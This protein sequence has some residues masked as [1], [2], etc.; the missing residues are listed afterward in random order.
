MD[1]ART[2]FSARADGRKSSTELPSSACDVAIVG[3]GPYGLAAAARLHELAG[4]DTRV[5]G[6]PM[7]FWEGM[8][9]GMLLRSA[10]EACSIGFPSGELS[11]DHYQTVSGAQFGK[12]VPLEAFVGYGCWFQRTAVPTVDQR[13]VASITHDQRGYH[14]VLDDRETI[15][16][17]RVIVAAGIGYFPWRPREFEQ[18]PPKLASH[19]SEHRDLSCFAGRNV[20]VV[21]GGQSALES[22]ALLHESGAA[23]EVVARAPHITWLHGGVVQRKLGAAKPLLYAKTDVGPAGISRLVA[24][25]GLFCSLPRSAQSVLAHRAIRPAGAK[26]L[27]SRLADVSIS[28]GRRVVAAVPSGDF[29]DLLLDDGSSR[30]AD[31]VILG[32]G[33]R[34]DI[35]DY[36]FLSPELLREVRCVGGYPVLRGGLESS[37]PGLHFAGAPAAWSFGPIMRFVSG[38]WFAAQA[39]AEAIG[40]SPVALQT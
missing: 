2:M 15:R 8:P 5:F 38:S 6:K 3:A 22:A 27:V 40:K 16:A 30:R 36:G 34:V 10:W 17:A 35:A 13:A 26:W 21:G 31:H 19:S 7:S 24:R 1:G 37:M 33:Y 14:L 28:T 32:T 9:R 25:P 12:P 23:V 39:L 4:L 11:I 29:V 20:V 18:L